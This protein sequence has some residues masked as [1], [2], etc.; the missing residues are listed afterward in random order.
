MVIPMLALRRLCAMLGW[1]AA[2]RVVSKLC[3]K[4]RT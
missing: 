4:G 3:Q 2:L 1:Q